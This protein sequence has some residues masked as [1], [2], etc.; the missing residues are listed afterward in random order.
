MDQA[1]FYYRS[2]F[3]FPVLYILLFPNFIVFISRVCSGAARA[4]LPWEL[5]APR[6]AVAPEIFGEPCIY[7]SDFFFVRW[8]K[9]SFLMQS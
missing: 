4:V 1:S 7:V 8:E 9:T 2:P 3:L 6:S 5:D